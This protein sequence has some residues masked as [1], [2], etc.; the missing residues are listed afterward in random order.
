MRHIPP[1]N[2]AFSLHNNYTKQKTV[3]LSTV[4]V[5]YGDPLADL[6]F[7]CYSFLSVTVLFCIVSTGGVLTAADIGLDETL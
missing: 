6:A 4:L 2:T 7:V 3:K 1:N 5:A